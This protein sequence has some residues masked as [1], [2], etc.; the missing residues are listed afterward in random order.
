[1]Q[2]FS[3]GDPIVLREIWDGRIW[4]AFP[5]IVVEDERDVFVN[6]VPAGVTTVRATGDDGSPLRLPAER[7]SLARTPWARWR[8]LAFSFAGERY[9]VLLFWNEP[10]DSFLG[11]Y[12][13]VETNLGRTPI[14]FDY[15]DHLLDVVIPADRSEWSWK[16]EDELDVAVARG[17]YTAEDAAAFRSAG[18]RGLRRVLDGAPPFDRDWSDWRPDPAWPTPTLPDGWDRV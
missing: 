8:V 10:D 1:M 13:N 6:L 2:R 12:V 14:G 9:A 3:P 4:G 17:I 16:D 7:W 11:Y 18:E 15:V 5:A